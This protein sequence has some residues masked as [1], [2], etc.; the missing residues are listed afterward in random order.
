M[1]TLPLYAYTP[2]PTKPVPVIFEDVTAKLMLMLSLVRH[3]LC[4]VKYIQTDHFVLILQ[5]LLG[6]VAALL[7]LKANNWFENPNHE[8]MGNNDKQCC[9]IVFCNQ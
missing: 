7:T 9:V 1:A 8:T 5:I 4:K 2:D 6:H 3:H